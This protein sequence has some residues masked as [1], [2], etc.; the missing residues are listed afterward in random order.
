MIK[1][2]RT[3]CLFFL[4][5]AYT[6]HF[7]GAESSEHVSL[8]LEINRALDK[9]LEWLYAQQSKP[10]G[11]W[12]NS[13]YPA[14]TALVLR[15]AHGHPQ[16]TEADKYKDQSSLGFSF[17]R[18][19]VQSDGGIYGKGL[20]SYNTSIC[21]TAF[22][23]QNNP[24]DSGIIESARRFII[25]QQSD[26]DKKGV[27]DNLFDGGVGYGS[28]WAHSD[29]SNTHL[30]LEALYYSKNKMSQREGE[31]FDLDW[32]AAIDFV[33]NCQNLPSSNKQAW[34]SGHE[35]DRGGFIYF[36]GNS[37]AGERENEDGST[38]LRS[39]GSM[40]YAGLL[41]FIYAEMKPE[42]PRIVAVLDWLNQNFS[43]EENPGMGKQGLFYYY[44]TMAKA[45]TL[46]GIEQ[47]EDSTSQKRDWRKELSLVLLNLQNHDGY[48]VNESGR[49][50]EKDPIL[51]TSYAM[52]ALERIYYAL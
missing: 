16:K 46:A 32:D 3:F 47:I 13:D 19:K 18:S 37:M 17:L 6:Y 28:T 24:Q 23:A 49:W 1:T 8:K 22:L 9:G 44:H 20:A 7:A 45:L 5:F 41:S 4:S 40:S 11:Y 25:N 26:F 51:V 2:S 33:S 35:L 48:W 42:D 52:L 27:Q 29:L 43:I 36:P 38:S 10:D 14:L 12:G 30:A 50:W 15:A 39:Y 21:L 31:V 34:V